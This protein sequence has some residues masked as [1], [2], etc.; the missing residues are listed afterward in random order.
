MT[1]LAV[2]AHS[3]PQG[4]I[5]PHVH[6]LIGQ[7]R[8]VADRVVVVSMAYLTPS[9]VHELAA[10][11]ELLHSDGNSAFGAWVHG[12]AHVCDGTNGVGDLERLLLVDDSLIGPLRPLAEILPPGHQGLRGVVGGASAAVSVDHRLLDVGA[13]VLADP[14]TQAFLKGVPERT[15][16]VNADPGLGVGLVRWVVAAGYPVDVVF[17]PSPNDRVR[18]AVA[19]LRAPARR[20]ANRRVSRI[21]RWIDMARSTYERCQEPV[22]VYSVLWRAALDARLPFVPVDVLRDDETGTSTLAALASRHPGV[23]DGVARYVERISSA[24]PRS[25][26]T[27]IARP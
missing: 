5:A 11:A 16:I 9:A 15:G 24:G 14:L 18:M 17:S 21:R 3:D 12:I 27:N 26:T 1:T 20:R 22:D 7:L 10:S 6:H 8:T 23:F 19:A 4:L 25:T 13:A 2:L